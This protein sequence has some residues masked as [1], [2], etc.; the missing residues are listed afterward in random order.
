ME[1]IEYIKYIYC[2]MVLRN[3][4][5]QTDF[6][7]LKTCTY[8]MMSYINTRFVCTDAAMCVSASSDQSSVFKNSALEFEDLVEPFLFLPCRVSFQKC[9]F[10][11]HCSPDRCSVDINAS[12][13]RYISFLGIIPW[14]QCLICPLQSLVLW[15]NTLFWERVEWNIVSGTAVSNPE[16]TGFEKLW[17]D[18]SQAIILSQYTKAT[19]S[20]HHYES[21]CFLTSSLSAQLFRLMWFYG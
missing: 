14:M 12:L 20:S 21:Q 5:L 11:G 19:S 4:F 8:G 1:Y 10:L 17:K 6:C 13:L 9:F 7:L 18:Y 15:T 3:I 2:K 16:P